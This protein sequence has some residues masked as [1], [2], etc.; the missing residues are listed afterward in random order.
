MGKKL[1][2]LKKIPNKESKRD[3]QESVGLRHGWTVVGVGGGERVN[4][5]DLVGG[6]CFMMKMREGELV[7]LWMVSVLYAMLK[8]YGDLCVISVLLLVVMVE[9]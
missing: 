5:D 6:G 3:Y 9:A 8:N 1:R 7:L 4:G 2:M